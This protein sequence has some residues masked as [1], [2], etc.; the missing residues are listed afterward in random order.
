MG[1]VIVF[2]II[3]ALMVFTAIKMVHSTNLV[4]SA[5][6]MAATF[7][8][9]ALIYLLLNADYLAVVQITVYVGAITVLFVFG[10]MLT[11]REYIEKSAQFNRYKLVGALIVAMLFIVFTVSILNTQFAISKVAQP[12]ST[13]MAIALL[14]LNDYSIAFQVA[15]V[16]LLVST[17]GAIVIG[18]GVKKTR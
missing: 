8:L 7:A 13:I 6:F 12:D 11:K 1:T 2:Y 3:A 18:K 4:H 15:G 10:I 14:L 9:I 5:L 16:L 17:I